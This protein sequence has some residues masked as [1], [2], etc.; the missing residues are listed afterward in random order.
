MPWPQIVRTLRQK[1]CNK[2]VCCQLCRVVM[3]GSGLR[4]SA[5]LVVV[6]VAIHYSTL[7]EICHIVLAIL[8]SKVIIKIAKIR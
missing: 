7:L 3:K 1:S 5:E 4:T 6:R 8:K 2:R